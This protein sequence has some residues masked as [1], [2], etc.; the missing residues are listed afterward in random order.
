MSV[1]LDS[2]AV[3]AWLHGRQPALTRIDDLIGARPMVSWI[4]LVEVDDR[5]ERDY[6][7]ERADGDL[8][9][10]AQSSPAI[11]PGWLV[12]LCEL[13]GGPE[14]SKELGDGDKGRLVL[15]Q[16]G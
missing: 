5:R 9:T 10:F 6:G 15:L 13:G 4:N 8:T 16:V 1:C 2:W 3:L 14:R 7:R 11:F 12:G